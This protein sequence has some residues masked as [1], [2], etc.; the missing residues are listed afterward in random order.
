M[1]EDDGLITVA[2]ASA[3]TGYT[4]QHIARLLRAG[5]IAGR[6]IGP[7]WVT[8]VAAL[9]VYRRSNPKPG[10]KPGRGSR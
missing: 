6:K 10:P 9:E 7:V 5:K 4:I 8:T 2:E 3:L 1:P